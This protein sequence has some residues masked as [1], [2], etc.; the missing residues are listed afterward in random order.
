MQPST[1]TY[2]HDDLELQG[3]ISYPKNRSQP[4]PAV[5]VVHDWTG[6]NDFAREKADQL[7]EMG[8]IGFAIDM[9]GKGQ[10][11]HTNDE[12]KALIT[13]LME[14][15]ALLSA[16]IE[17]AFETLTAMPGVD[18]TKIAAIGF[19]FG[20][21]CVLDLARRGTDLKGV[22]SFHGLL[23]KPNY[24]TSSAISAKILV[25]HGYDDP[26]VKPD[27]VE[28]FCKE[29]T[30]AGADWQ[31]HQYGH[32][33]H[34]FTNPLAHDVALG[35]VYNAVAERRSLKAMKDFFAEIF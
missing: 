6:C 14:D 33:T 3:Y 2:H 34:A 29:M 5:L 19:C 27:A 31:V 32:T 11:G 10:N 24:K 28:A 18:I 16:R 17:T 12:K 22:V 7:A 8:Y 1:L 15:R 26:M 20:G 23:N 9:F 4:C 25:L 21:L 30:E 13:P 35:T